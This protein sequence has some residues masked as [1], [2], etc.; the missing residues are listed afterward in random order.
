[1]MY[2]PHSSVREQSGN[3]TP[4]STGDE[5]PVKKKSD[6]P[7]LTLELTTKL[8]QKPVSAEMIERVKHLEEQ[9]VCSSL[10]IRSLMI[11]PGV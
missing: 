10:I 3:P 7:L 9:K 2:E 1:M 8:R 6:K 11:N 5:R 4:M